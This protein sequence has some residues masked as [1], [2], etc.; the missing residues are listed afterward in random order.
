MS[1][2]FVNG[3]NLKQAIEYLENGTLLVAN[4]N[5]APA[6]DNTKAYS[7]GEV[8]SYQTLIYEWIADAPAGTSPTNTSYA[9]EISL[10]ELTANLQTKIESG[11]VIANQAKSSYAINPVSAESGTAQDAP[12]IS[13]GTGTANN[14]ASVDVPPV[15]QHLEKQG[16]TVVENQQIKNPTF[17][18]NANWSAVNASL[19]ISSG[20]ATFTASSQHGGIDS[21]TFDVIKDHKYLIMADIKLTTATTDIGVYLRSSGGDVLTSEIYTASTTNKQTVINIKSASASATGANLRIRDRRSSSRDAVEVDNVY[22]HDLTQYFN[23]NSSIPSDL[24]SNPSHWS[25]YYNGTGA[26]NTGTIRNAP[27]RYLVTTERNLFGGTMER[28]AYSGSTGEAVTYDAGARCD[29]YILV[30]PNVKYYLFKGNFAAPSDTTLNY[31]LYQY[32]ANKNFISK[33][34]NTTGIFELV[35]NCRYIKF[36]FIHS[37]SSSTVLPIPSEPNVTFSLYYSPEQGGEGYDEYYPYEEPNTYD[38]GT[39]DLLAFDT[40][41]PDGTWHKNTV[42]IDL[43]TLGFSYVS[44]LNCWSTPTNVTALNGSHI[45][46]VVTN[47]EG[48]ISTKYTPKA[49]TNFSQRATGDIFINVGNAQAFIVTGDSTT[50][51]SG[52][53][54]ILVADSAQT[55]SQGTSFASNIDDND[56]GMMYWLDTDGNLVSTPQGCK[57]FYPF[58]YVLGL[59]TLFGYTSGDMTD[60]VRKSDIATQEE[61]DEILAILQ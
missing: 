58:D 36:A 17:D 61:I 60:L 7:T 9:R 50:A 48:I 47:G 30:V 56:Y 26:Y 5:M 52:H 37:G 23:G 21:S 19:S 57:I 27:G 41:D 45:S 3:D 28:G 8:V 22:V 53:I 42:D 40:K 43:S 20:K 13:Q 16:Y 51:P 49:I 31:N 4:T 12:F 34:E 10:A 33:I 11:A 15:A 38:T 1:T 29:G 39:E 44:N 14:T 35:S 24:L 46:G 59:D 32:D 2:K 54:Q 25:W 55:T 6:Y 18:T